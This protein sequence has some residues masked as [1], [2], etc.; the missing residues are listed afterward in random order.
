MTADRRL[1]GLAALVAFCAFGTVVAGLSSVSLLDP[2]GPLEP[3]WRIN[4]EAR[5]GFAVLG[6]WSALLLLVV[7]SACALT[8][9]GLWI[10]APWGRRLA[11]ALIGA[12]AIGDAVGALVRDDP[13]TLIG[14]PIAAAVVAYLLSDRVRAQFERAEPAS[15]VAA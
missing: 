1:P 12:N 7:A 9:F 11:I 5:A 10:R 6:R 14:V 2:G 8:G 15:R 4:P 13:R 3:M